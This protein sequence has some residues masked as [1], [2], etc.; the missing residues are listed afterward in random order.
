MLQRSVFESADSPY[1]RLLDWA[2]VDYSEIANLV[3]LQGIEKTLHDLCQA[4]VY[5]TVEEF[6][7]KQPARRGSAEFH[8]REKDFNNPYFPG[9]V[10]A[11]TGGSRSAGTRTAYDFDHL[12]EKWAIQQVLRLDS[13]GVLGCPLAMWLPT[14]PGAGPVALL[15]YLKAG[16]IPERWFSPVEN[17]GFAPALRSRL[18]TFY[19]VHYGRLFEHRIPR[20]THVPLDDAHVIARWMADSLGR[21][22]GCCLT[23]YVSA[24]VRVAQAAVEKGLD[25]TGAVFSV[26][27]EPLTPGKLHEIERCG[28]KVRTV[29]AFMET[30]IVALGCQDPASPDDM[31]LLSDCVSAIQ[32]WREVPHAGTGVNAFLFTTLLPSSPKILLNAESGDYGT[33]E[34]RHCNCQ[35]EEAGFLTHLSRIRGFDKLTSAGMSFVGRDIMRILEEVLPTQFG[36]DSTHYQIVEEEDETGHT[37][38]SLFISPRLGQIDDAAVLSLVLEEL[39]RGTEAHRLMSHIWK[40]AKTLRVERREPVPTARGKLLPLHISRTSLQQDDR[41][42]VSTQVKP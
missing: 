36:G 33:M 42:G 18:G 38:L 39:A 32:Y 8:F 26:S 22:G 3:Q 40:Q 7:G 2:G 30:G 21:S 24:A 20:P 41:E 17:R 11:R 1:R 34:S 9:H 28:A 37:R 35:L 13:H 23:T 31:H 16:I 6:K 19:I 15:A 25:L 14:M 12:A 4:G 29:Y 10:S 5:V 27:S